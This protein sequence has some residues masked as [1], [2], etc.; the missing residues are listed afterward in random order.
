MF[1]N[2]LR[3]IK[4]EYLNHIHENVVSNLTSTFY[5]KKHKVNKVSLY[6]NKNW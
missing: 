2:F 4:F 3:L 5:K 1:K 6:P